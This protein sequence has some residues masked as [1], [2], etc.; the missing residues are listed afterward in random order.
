MSSCDNPNVEQDSLMTRRKKYDGKTKACVKC[1]E[2]TGHVVIRH[3][4][5]CKSC[6]F[7]LIEARFKK[8]LEPTI[9]S[10]GPR[11]KTLKAA[12]SLVIG[13]SGGIGSRTLLDLVAKTY[14]APREVDEEKL[15][16]GTN[17][18]RNKEQGVWTGKPIVCFVDTSSAFSNTSLVEEARIIVESYP[19]VFD[20]RPILLEDAFDQ[21]WWRKV[22]GDL[23]ESASGLGLDITDQDLRLSYASTSTSECSP[24]T[25]LRAYLA[26]LPTRTAFYNAIQT[27]TRVL[28][29]QTAASENASHLLLGT[30]LTSLSVNLISGIAQG[31]GFSVAEEA[32]EEW[33]PEPGCGMKLKVVRPLRDVGMKECAM[34]TYWHNLNVIPSLNAVENNGRNAIHTLTRDFIFGLETDYPATVSTIARTCAKLAP[35]ETPSGVCLLCQRPTHAEVQAWKAQISIRTYHDAASAVSG[36]TRPP[37]LTEN[38]IASLTKKTQDDLSTSSNTLTPFLCYACHTTLTSRSSRGTTLTLPPGI[39]PTNIPIPRWITQPM[40]LSPQRSNFLNADGEVFQSLKQTPEDL[41]SRIEGFILSD[42]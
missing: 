11:R 6:F 39:S 30:S 3:A 26:S 4:V 23:S 14:Y 24:Q 8:S 16:G 42:E 15:R 31:A 13:F 1:K 38:E 17:H 28:L 19:G 10:S 40:A 27:L 18:P 36:N 22:G 21:D 7:P 9:N 20:F 41:K 33:T 34:W 25:A 5:Y 35:K 2:N 29:L 12:G 32:I 37:H